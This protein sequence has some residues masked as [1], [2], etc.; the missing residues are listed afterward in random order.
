MPVSVNDAPTAPPPA[1][2]EGEDGTAA[3]KHD[4]LLAAFLADAPLDTPDLPEE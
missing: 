2:Q 1:S 4:D 3:S